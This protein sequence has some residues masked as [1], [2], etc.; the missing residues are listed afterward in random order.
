MKDQRGETHK[1]G[2]TLG[3]VNLGADSQGMLET[4]LSVYVFIKPAVYVIFQRTH[5][6]LR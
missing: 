1:Y 2:R 5:Q 3:I 6:A 4:F